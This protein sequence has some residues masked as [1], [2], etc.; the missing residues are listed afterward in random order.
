MEG[1]VKP[2]KHIIIAL[3]L[4]LL[5]ASLTLTAI[6]SNTT[7]AAYTPTTSG[8]Q[9]LQTTT[10]GKTIITGLHTVQS[11]VNITGLS[12]IGGTIS[13]T[14]N[15]ATNVTMGPG[16]TM[17]GLNGQPFT[18]EI[19]ANSFTQA[20]PLPP[21]SIAQ[22]LLVGSQQYP[23]VFQA[24]GNITIGAIYNSTGKI[25]GGCL[26]QTASDVYMK[27]NSSRTGVSGFIGDPLNTTRV[28]SSDTRTLLFLHFLFFSCL[29]GSNLW[30]VLND[31]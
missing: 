3:A 6:T 31:V 16:V 1:N 13:I 23:A 27:V 30:E 19:Y 29:R 9:P 14:A 2:R 10:T 20:E 12:T 22:T 17:T 5:I 26:D 8:A 11:P 25:V 4:V 18:T 7:V 21:G 15:G 24:N 28:I